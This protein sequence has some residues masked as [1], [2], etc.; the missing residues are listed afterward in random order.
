MKKILLPVLSLFLL[1]ACEKEEPLNVTEQQAL[2]SDATAV[3]RKNLLLDGT[4]ETNDLTQFDRYEG[5]PHE[6]DVQGRYYRSYPKSLRVEINSHEFNVGGGRYRAEVIQNNAGGPN[7]EQDRWFGFSMRVP[8]TW[9]VISTT[10]SQDI[11]FQIHDRPDECEMYRTPPLVLFIAKDRFKATIHSDANSCSN[12]VNPKGA[13]TTVNYVLNEPLIKGSWVDW[14]IHVK[15]SIKDDGVLEIWQNGKKITDYHGPIGYNDQKQM[16]LK[17]GLYH[18]ANGD[19]WPDGLKQRLL[20]LD[21]IR[22]GG[23]KATYADVKPLK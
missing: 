21:E 23:P 13:G 19:G 1:T 2:V 9:R 3:M 11:F 6:L 16:Y 12:G 4:F 8:E 5:V 17:Q 20:Y 7:L 14:V 10:K 22:M 15:W 18:I